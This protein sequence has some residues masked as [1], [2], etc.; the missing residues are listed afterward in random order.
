MFTSET[1]P[2][3]NVPVQEV[4]LI[5]ICKELNK[6]S[7]SKTLAERCFFFCKF[8]STATD[9]DPHVGLKPEVELHHG[10]GIRHGTSIV[11]SA[12]KHGVTYQTSF[13]MK[14]VL[15]SILFIPKS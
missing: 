2:F 5:F 11:T 10:A 7:I 12:R 8:L 4:F 6:K 15:H 3:L 13:G 9:R 14:I 1:W